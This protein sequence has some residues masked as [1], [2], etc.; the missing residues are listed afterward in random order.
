MAPLDG[1]TEP[2][3]GPGNATEP[4]ARSARTFMI[5]VASDAGPR[6]LTFQT[7]NLL[8][9]RM[10]DN[11]LALNHASVSRRHAKIS[12]GARGA[13]LEDMG[14]QNGSTINGK[15][16]KDQPSPLRPG[17]IVRIGHVP[18]FYFGFI[19]PSAPPV[20]ERVEHSVVLNPLVSL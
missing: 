3:M 18:L 8:I 17:D 2:D 20:A 10:P 19:D 12:F 1:I 9:G 5:G 13:Q 16:V 6:L 14:S 4:S 15:A 7:S 11:H